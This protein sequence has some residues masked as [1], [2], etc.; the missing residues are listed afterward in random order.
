M[1][2]PKHFI[3]QKIPILNKSYHVLIM[4]VLEVLKSRQTT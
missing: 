1:F 4:Y 2:T 3:I